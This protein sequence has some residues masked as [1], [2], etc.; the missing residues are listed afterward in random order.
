MLQEIITISTRTEMLGL[1]GD[2]KIKACTIVSDIFQMSETCTVEIFY[3]PEDLSVRE[4]AN[5]LLQCEIPP[6][7]KNRI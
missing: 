1:K 3:L 4:R 7:L 2:T 6:T 5:V